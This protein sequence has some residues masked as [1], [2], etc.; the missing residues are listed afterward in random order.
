LESLARSQASQSSRARELRWFAVIQG[1]DV[2]VESGE[3]LQYQGELIKPRSRS[4]IP[5]KLSDNPVPGEK[6]A[7]AQL[8]KVCLSRYAPSF[9]MVISPSKSHDD[10]WSIIPKSW[11]EQARLRYDSDPRKWDME[12]LQFDWRIGVDVGDGVDPHAIS[13]WR[14]NV[15]YQARIYETQTTARI[16]CG[17]LMR[18]RRL[19]DGWGKL[20]LRLIELV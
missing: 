18:L 1:K 3:P 6:L 8:F 9:S 12:A 5:A 11:L 15:L 14:G 7:I 17:W 2:E 19:F 10:A 13:L 4:F 16:L 20:G